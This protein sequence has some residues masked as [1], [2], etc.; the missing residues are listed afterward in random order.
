MHAWG[1][2][3]GSIWLGCCKYTVFRV[4]CFFGVE[5]MSIILRWRCVGAW[6]DRVFRL[7]DLLLGLCTMSSST[8]MCVIKVEG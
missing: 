3:M 6:W 5:V 8:L 4:G 7:L 1:V 2:E